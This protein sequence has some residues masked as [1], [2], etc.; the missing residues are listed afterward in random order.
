MSNNNNLY[1]YRV[2]EN[3]TG[4]PIKAKTDGVEHENNDRDYFTL[5]EALEKTDQDFET[6]TIEPYYWKAPV[7]SAAYIAEMVDSF[8]NNEI[9]RVDNL[10]QNAVR[11]EI[12]T[13]FLEFAKYLAADKAAEEWKAH[14]PS[15]IQERKDG[16]V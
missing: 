2:I 1:Y 10:A 3:A 11:Q 9:N 16:N 12:K 4:R 5:P 14:F 13:V 15:K 8:A 7:D 6:F